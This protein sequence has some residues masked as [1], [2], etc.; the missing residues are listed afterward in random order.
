M[1]DDLEG[2]D[3]VV[4][5]LALDQVFGSAIDISDLEILRCG[6]ILGDADRV[7]V[8]IDTSDIS[9]KSCHSLAGQPAAATYIKYACALDREE[10]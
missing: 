2:Q 9:P 1:F 6:M 5:S 7:G 3:D 4:S 8:S 10:G